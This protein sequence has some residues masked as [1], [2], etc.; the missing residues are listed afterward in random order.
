M[1][2]TARLG[3]ARLSSSSN[4]LLQG[5]WAAVQ[6]YNTIPVNSAHSPL[7]K[8]AQA[9]D[10]VALGAGR[11][12]TSKPPQGKMTNTKR[13]NALRALAE[14]VGKEAEIRGIRLLKGPTDYKTIAGD[15][16]HQSYWLERIDPH[17]RAG[18]ILSPKWQGWLSD[19]A[20]I[21]SKQSF[22]DFIGAPALDESS[23]QYYPSIAAN[24]ADK[25][26]VRFENDELLDHDGHPVHT[27]YMSTAFSGLGW[28]IFVCSP[29]WKMFVNSHQVGVHHH[30][31]FLAGG[32][33]AAAGELVVRN[34]VIMC[35]TAKSGHY[36]PTPENIRSFLIKF[37]HVIPG[38]AVVRPNLLDIKEHKQVRFYWAWQYRESGLKA[39]PLKRGE[40]NLT[41]PAW[42]KTSPEVQQMINKVPA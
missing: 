35:V 4:P 1:L 5:I 12:L 36:T 28:A 22:W 40:V 37:Q 21:S 6:A 17:H 26:Q 31:S 20:A 7:P 27:R 34:G 11:Y 8:V 16:A 33:V 15:H 19:A 24:E 2:D 23:V 41:L 10:A 18:Y 30:S 38:G 39:P 32:A 9:L 25:Y 13:W 42:A 14:Q 3:A 29:E